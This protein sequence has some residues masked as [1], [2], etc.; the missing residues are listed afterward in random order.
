MVHVAL[1]KDQGGLIKNHGP[2][3]LCKHG[4]L[5]KQMS[6]TQFL[7]KKKIL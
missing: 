3:L 1:Q 5:N 6:E 4:P 7:K 2:H